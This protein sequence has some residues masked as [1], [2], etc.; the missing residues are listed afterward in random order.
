M[1]KNILFA[2]FI[3]VFKLISF[4]QEVAQ[5]D[6]FEIYTQDKNNKILSAVFKSL[7]VWLNL[8]IDLWLNWINKKT[9]TIPTKE[10]K[11]IILAL[12]MFV[13]IQKKTKPRIAKAKEALSPDKKVSKVPVINIIEMYIL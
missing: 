12:K 10:Y 4:G 6:D 9:N 3:I 8:A 7:V 13:L 2:S 11:K 1:Q 5:Y